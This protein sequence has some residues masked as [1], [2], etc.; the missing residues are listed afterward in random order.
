[1]REQISPLCGWGTLAGYQIH[2]MQW[3]VRKGQAVLSCASC[4]VALSLACSAGRVYENLPGS[5]WFL[6]R[7]AVGSL[8]GTRI[9]YQ[10]Q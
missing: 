2:M 1:M 5:Q 7:E 4:F 8:L 10:F 9:D 3:L 6:L